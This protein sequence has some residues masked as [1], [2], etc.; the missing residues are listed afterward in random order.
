MK[1]QNFTG[2]DAYP[3]RANRGN[4]GK[5]LSFDAL[6]RVL[7]ALMCAATLC[8]GLLLAPAELGF[9]LIADLL[10][11]SMAGLAAVV[12][13]IIAVGVIERLTD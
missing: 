3:P 6:S 5:S 10:G 9:F 1:N 4:R 11:W 13:V 2:D 12:A 8:F 7:V